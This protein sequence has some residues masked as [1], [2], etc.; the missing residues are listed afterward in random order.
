MNIFIHCIDLNVAIKMMSVDNLST[1][2]FEVIYIKKIK[3]IRQ[4]KFISGYKTLKQDF[5]SI[6][7]TCML[8]FVINT[9]T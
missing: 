9:M 1:L 3:S 7:I 4:E 6:Y 5:S 2:Y 8:E